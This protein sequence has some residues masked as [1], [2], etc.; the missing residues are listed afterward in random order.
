MDYGEW[1]A[2][3]TIDRRREREMGMQGEV[4]IWGKM[5]W[6]HNWKMRGRTCGDIVRGVG[7]RRENAEKWTAQC[8]FGQDWIGIY[9]ERNGE[10]MMR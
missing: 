7:R 1:F 2:E 9:P 6:K 5:Y 10:V 8:I 4:Y 3:R